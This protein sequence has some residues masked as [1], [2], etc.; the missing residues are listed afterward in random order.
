MTETFTLLPLSPIRRMIAARTAEAKRTIPHFRLCTDIEM[1]ALHAL[2]QARSVER[3]SITDVFVK[4]CAS[5]LMQA[6]GLNLQWVEGEI[7]QL[8]S[9]DIAVV[10]ALNDGL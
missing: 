7:R 3:L 6:P 5:V 8:K 4:A 1:D 2:R 9:A 10:V